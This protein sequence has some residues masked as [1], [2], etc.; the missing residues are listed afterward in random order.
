MTNTAWEDDASNPPMDCLRDVP[1][2][3]LLCSTLFKH[4]PQNRGTS[5][6]LFLN[7]WEHGVLTM[8]QVILMFRSGRSQLCGQC[9]R[10]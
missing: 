7:R 1:V 9:V 4:R 3:L 10:G 6:G 2:K 5:V 8:Y